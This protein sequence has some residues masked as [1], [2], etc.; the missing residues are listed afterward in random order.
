[1]M[2]V[3]RAQSSPGTVAV[4]RLF[5]WSLF[6]ATLSAVAGCDSSEPPDISKQAT[7]PTVAAPLPGA[8]TPTV[9]TKLHQWQDC[10]GS[11][12][13]WVRRAIVAIAG[14][15]PWGQGE[16]LAWTDAIAAV[17]RARGYKFND[18]A[19]TG[20]EV[21]WSPAVWEARRIV[22]LA[23]T[24]LPSYRLRWTDFVLDALRVNRIETKA[25]LKCYTQP[26]DDYHDKGELA[27]FV[28]DHTP[29]TG[30]AAPSVFTLGQLVSSAL[31]KDDLSVVWRANLF[32]MVAKPF[33]AAN[34]GAKELERSR[35]QDFGRVFDAAYLH[36]DFVCMGCHN[37]QFSTTYHPDPHRNRAWPV[38]GHFEAALFGS[39]TGKHPQE[40]EATKGPSDLRAHAVLRHGG[41]VDAKNGASP[42]G[43]HKDCGRFKVPKDPDPLGHDGYFGLARGATVSVYDLEAS[44][45]RGVDR[46]VQFGLQRLDDGTVDPDDAL[47]WLTAQTIVEQVWQDVMGAP[48]TLSNY[49][50]RTEAQRDT[51]ERLTT[52][53][54]AKRY[55]L[56]HLLADIAVEPLF[57]PPPPEA[58]CG[59]AYAW[60][61]VLDA[62]SNHA[63]D[64][65]QRNNGPG[66]GVLALP[67]RQLRRSLHGALGWPMAAEYPGG[68]EQTF[69][70]SVGVFLK[71]A[72][73]GFRSL[74]FAARL[75]WEARYGTCAKPN[76]YDFVDLVAEKATESANASW[77]DAVALLKDRLIGEPF[78]A[79]SETPH[80]QALLGAKL[81]E[82]VVGDDAAMRLRRV[83]GALV[84]TPQFLL[85]GLVAPDRQTTPLLTPGSV[86]Y[87]PQCDNIVTAFTA[88][89]TGYAVMCT[90]S[91]VSA[92][93]N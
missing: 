66:D 13:A 11:D 64:P 1:M 78:V 57:N 14:R 23:M 4:V 91:G 62:W 43:W 49:F 39:P 28:R 68:E 84:S 38:F 45:H 89:K 40:E 41:V 46:I 81:N 29:T 12:Q 72:E 77:G 63:S 10:Q 32:A 26:G 44:L 85:G 59:D 54:V 42:W 76:A 74:D 47:A 92:T 18:G 37:S 52:R 50:P 20:T 61:R 58:G 8:P 86:S 34:V 25:Q 88:A 31:R 36:R 56:R 73:P 60:P 2:T 80:V 3:H 75:A 70:L 9:P 65:A 55:A 22:A 67:A 79:E 82:K 16:V 33:E 71:D 93:E 48:L 15:R 17:R 19:F 51:L 27:G 5:A 6:A 21:Q 87:G 90:A 30:D 83:C 24:E 69:Q 7:F 53:F 35:R